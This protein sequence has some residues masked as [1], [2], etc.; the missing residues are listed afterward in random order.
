MLFDGL[1]CDIIRP[2]MFAGEKNARKNPTTC[3]VTEA[4]NLPEPFLPPV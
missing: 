4:S 2:L 3:T 1:M